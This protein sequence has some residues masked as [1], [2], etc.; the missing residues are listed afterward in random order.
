MV[1][2]IGAVNAALAPMISALHASGKVK[3]LQRV[4]TLAA[5]GIAFFCVPAGL[6]LVFAGEPI[7]G[8]FGAEFKAGYR[9][10]VI[11]AGGQLVNAL[12]GSVGLLTMMTGHQGRAVRVVAVCVLLN[13][14]LN[15]I[16]IPRF[17]IAG[18]AAATAATTILSNLLLLVYVVR[19]LGINPTAFTLGRRGA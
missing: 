15:A 4:V 3:E 10:L 9:A 5:R 11:L 6:V 2:A 7:L 8:L 13:I 17:G 12:S 16:L 19:H 18:A 14:L 1:F